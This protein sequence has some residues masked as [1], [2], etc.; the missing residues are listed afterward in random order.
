MEIPET[1]ELEINNG[2]ILRNDLGKELNNIRQYDLKLNKDI[3]KLIIEIS[4]NND[5]LF[6]LRQTNNISF[7]YYEKKYKYEDIL[8][9]LNLEKN[10]YNNILKIL[11]FFDV[12]VKN[13]KLKISKDNNKNKTFLVLILNENNKVEE[14]FI[15]LEIKCMT[16]KKMLNIIIDEINKI[17]NKE[18]LSNDRN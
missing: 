15:N 7:I 3:Y 4:S 1:V 16:E 8:K 17:K 10:K 2:D 9:H 5:I 14:Y 6:S 18:N 13:E 12:S 11:E